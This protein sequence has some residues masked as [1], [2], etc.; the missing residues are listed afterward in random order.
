MQN[1]AQFREVFEKVHSIFKEVLENDD[2][3]FKYETNS[4][5]IEEW[6]SLNHI[7]LVITIETKFGIKFTAKE[8][9]S[10][11]N[12]GEMCEGIIGKLS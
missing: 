11:N 9:Q 4:N 7:A 10:F 2:I 12:V 6:D 3:L 8:M 1:N 5:D